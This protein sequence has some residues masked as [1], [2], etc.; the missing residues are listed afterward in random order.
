MRKLLWRVI[1]LFLW[2]QEK[3]IRMLIEHLHVVNLVLV[4]IIN[5]SH[6]FRTSRR[7]I[8]GCQKGCTIEQILCPW[9]LPFGVRFVTG[10]CEL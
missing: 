2:L 4:Q 9:A 3:E 5:A 8:N 7:S 10:N 1:L 6:F